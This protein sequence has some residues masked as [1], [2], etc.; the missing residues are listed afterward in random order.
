[1][2]DRVT[3]SVADGIADVRLNR[4]DKMNA[5]DSAMFDALIDAGREVARDRSVRAV[6]LSGEGRSFCAGLD[7]SSF[8]A[9]AG[10]GSGSGSGSGGSLFQNTNESPAN[11]AQRAAWIWTEVPVPVIAAI[12]GVAFGAGLQIAGAADIR[13]I[14]PDARMS[15]M[16]S[17]W[18]LVPDMSGTQT[19]RRLLR[20]DVL[21]ELTYTARI[22]SGEEAVSL[23]LATH[24]SDSPRD[25][26][27]ELAREIASRSPNAIRAAK[28]LLDESGRVSVSEGLALEAKL[29]AGLI[30]KPNQIEAVKSN[31]EKRAPQYR[32]PE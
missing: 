25:A 16:E 14:A 13:F 24:L 20:L 7:V 22:V 26:A 21:K 18:G 9:M 31:L 4:P 8:G 19:L 3:I 28:K 2:S 30:G 23:G 17:K 32:D 15:I 5:V 1:M 29:Q 27:F 6:V 10:D 11:R 12:H